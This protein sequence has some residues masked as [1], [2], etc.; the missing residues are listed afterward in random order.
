MLDCAKKSHTQQHWEE[1]KERSVQRERRETIETQPAAFDTQKCIG[2]KQQ[3]W[4]TAIQFHCFRGTIRVSISRRRRSLSMY[5]LS[6]ST[7]H[8][9]PLIPPS[10]SIDAE[11]KSANNGHAASWRVRGSMAGQGLFSLLGTFGW[12]GLNWWESC[13]PFPIPPPPLSSSR[14]AFL[15][16]KQIK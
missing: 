5:D 15:C 9:R 2:V 11:I 6:I 16:R 10:L 14:P 3:Q 13:A 8:P 4:A 1:G 7:L 12:L